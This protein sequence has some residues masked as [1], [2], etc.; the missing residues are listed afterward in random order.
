MIEDIVFA[1]PDDHGRQAARREL[2]LQPLESLERPCRRVEWNPAWPG[3]REHASRRVAQYPFVCLLRALPEFLSVNNREVNTASR[4][5]VVA[6]EK[7]GTDER[8]MH[9]PPWE[10]ARV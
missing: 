7:V 2:V 4:K 1:P 5:R 9:H 3:P 6:T 8:R 10:D